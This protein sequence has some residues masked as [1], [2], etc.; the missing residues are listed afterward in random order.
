MREQLCACLVVNVFFGDF[1]SVYRFI[2]SSVQE[3]STGGLPLS[4]PHTEK[5]GED[6]KTQ[7][8]TTQT[9]EGFFFSDTGT[10]RHRSWCELS[11]ST[12][13]TCRAP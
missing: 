6:T 8:H 5:P 7:L 4:Y 13:S 1:G 11:D 3:N 2:G 10:Q 9:G 12:R